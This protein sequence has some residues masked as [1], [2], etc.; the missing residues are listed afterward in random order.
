MTKEEKMAIQKQEMTKFMR[1]FENNSLDFNNTQL[2]QQMQNAITRIFQLEIEELGYSYRPDRDDSENTF[3]LRFINDKSITGRGYYLGGS[4]PS[5]VYNTASLYRGLESQNVNER[6][7]TCKTLFKT[8]FHE[9][10]H[11]RQDLMAKTNVSSKNGLKY[12]RDFALHKYLEEVWYIGNKNIS[13]YDA[14]T[15]ENNANEVG[16]RQYLETMGFSDSEIKDLMDIEIGK[17][18]TSRYKA[19]NVSTRDGQSHY[20]YE[21]QERD[22]VTV[23]ILDDLICVKGK[24]EILEQYP[25]LQKE[26]NLDGSKKSAI[27]LIKNMQQEI[28]EISQNQSL[29]EQ[30][31]KALIKDGQEMYYELIYRQIENS[32]PEQISQIATQ[33]GK[34]ES[35]ALFDNMSYYFQC[36]LE[37]RLGKSAQMASAQARRKDFITP[38]NNGTIAVEQNGKIVQMSFDEFI[39]TINL[40]LL[41]RDFD[42]PK[43]KMTA[44][45]FIESFFFSRIAQSGKVTLKDG[46]EISAKEYIEQ[47][48]LKIKEVTRDNPPIKFIRETMQSE[49]PWTIHQENRERL[50]QY[51][52]GKKG[53]IAQVT[54]K[55]EQYDPT[56]QNTQQ[57]KRIEAHQRKMQWIRDFIKDYEDTEE[58]SA[59]ALKSNCED[60]NIRRVVESIKTGKFIEI[61]DN[62]AQN[63]KKDPNWYLGKLTPAMARLLKEADNLTIDGRE[64]YL[65]QFAT[66]PEVNKLLIQIRDSEYAKQMHTDAENN[67]RTGNKPHYDRT[68]AEK[69]KQYAQEYFRSNKGNPQQEI[70]YRKQFLANDYLRVYSYNVKKEQIPMIRMQQIALTRVLARQA[71]KVP[72]EMFYDENRREW[73]CIT[74]TQMQQRKQQGKTENNNFDL[75]DQEYITLEDITRDTSE[76]GLQDIN[77]VTQ[78]TRQ[79]QEQR[80]NQEQQVSR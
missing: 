62:N 50:E 16:Y 52:G 23:P 20:N 45:K 74:D 4:K 65:E 44:E 19:N 25:L 67:R 40:Q 79:L 43:G 36:E 29:T 8:V 3:G 73:C 61:F 72:S 13:N 26:Y 32:T 7:L 31:K 71:G 63:D 42:T 58:P 60:E 66:I 38:F 18:N 35:K 47:Y 11:H 49:S 54:E 68:L 17:L 51:Y 27:E 70:Q 76:V 10:Q 57:Q 30:E 39:K 78:S 64:N 6:L 69:D 48:V 12:A 14:Y 41:Q 21:L 28:Q 5:I 55:V 34:T 56:K 9:I 1:Y 80:T 77:S 15:A 22:D 59:Y 33:I 46:T 2:L 53:I 37:N 24:T 75:S